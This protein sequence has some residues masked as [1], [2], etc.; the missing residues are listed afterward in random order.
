MK[1]TV[2]KKQLSLDAICLIVFAGNHGNWGQAANQS[3]K[4]WPTSCQSFLVHLTG[5]LMAGTRGLAFTCC[6]RLQKPTP[7]RI[8]QTRNM[9]SVNGGHNKSNEKQSQ[10]ASKAERKDLLRFRDKPWVRIHVAPPRG[11]DPGPLT[12]LTFHLDLAAVTGKRIMF[13]RCIC[14]ISWLQMASFSPP[15]SWILC[16]LTTHYSHFYWRNVLFFIFGSLDSDF[17]ALQDNLEKFEKWLERSARVRLKLLKDT[18]F[19]NTPAE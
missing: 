2:V 6:L 10:E 19:C 9:P 12:G 18:I 16:I 14:S 7:R 4:A 15:L 11:K 8:K 17:M 5:A 1:A 13:I 3:R